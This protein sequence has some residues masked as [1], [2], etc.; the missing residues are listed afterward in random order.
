MNYY[1]A[2]GRTPHIYDVPPDEDFWLVMN[3]ILYA[4]DSPL[5]YDRYVHEM[6]LMFLYSLA[7]NMVNQWQQQ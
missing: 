4:K 1:K 2:T 5:N 7:D 6:P 3:V